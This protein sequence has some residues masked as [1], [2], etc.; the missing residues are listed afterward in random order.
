MTMRFAAEATLLA[1]LVAVC[2]AV[3]VALRGRNQRE[4]MMTA[5]ALWPP[6]YADPV[7]D[8]SYAAGAFAMPQPPLPLSLPQQ[9]QQAPPSPDPGGQPPPRR[10]GRL[11]SVAQGDA[12]VRRGLDAEDLGGQCS[13]AAGSGYACTPMYSALGQDM[14]APL[15][16]CPR[17]VQAQAV[18]ALLEM[19]LEQQQQEPVV[20]PRAAYV[21]L[22]VL[23]EPRMAGSSVFV[24]CVA[25]DRERFQPYI[26]HLYV[27]PARRGRGVGRRLLEFAERYV[28]TLRFAEVRLR[29]APR[30]VA[31]YERLGWRIESAR[32]E[33]GHTDAVTVLMH[34]VVEGDS[35][36]LRP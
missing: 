27:T 36:V 10:A 13:Y 26:D 35:P 32:H 2:V 15:Q 11:S 25:V 31:F 23:F 33:A 8:G 29:C 14:I 17:D 18:A 21:L 6:T 20:D 1:T 3:S 9:Q 5:D 12:G 24:G 19:Q 16:L 4:P 30:L 34:K 22:F 28:A 7:A